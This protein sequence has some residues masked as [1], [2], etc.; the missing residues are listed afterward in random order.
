MNVNSACHQKEKSLDVLC[1]IRSYVLVI[2]II[3]FIIFWSGREN[4]VYF[5]PAVL[6]KIFNLTITLLL[7]S[8]ICYV[9]SLADVLRYLNYLI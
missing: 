9:L 7:H 5:T 1:H 8:V 4:K 3:N 6:H 2:K